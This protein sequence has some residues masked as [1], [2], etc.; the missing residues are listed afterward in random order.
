MPSR[1][2]H[3]RK[4]HSKRKTSR[5]VHRRRTYKRGGVASSECD[6]EIINKFNELK[7]RINNQTVNTIED[8]YGEFSSLYKDAKRIG[9]SNQCLDEL[10][11]FEYTIKP[12]GSMEKGPL[13]LKMNALLSV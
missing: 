3:R 10:I 8:Y 1:K 13:T 7:S 12:N 6:Q 2:T 11:K 4:H 9:A 5:T